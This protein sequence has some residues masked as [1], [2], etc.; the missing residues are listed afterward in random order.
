MSCS[1]LSSFVM[2]LFYYGQGVSWVGCLCSVYYVVFC[3]W[4]GLVLNQ[5]QVSL[6]VSDWESYLGYPFPTCVSWVF[7]FRV[8]VC[9]TRNYFGLV[10]SR[11]VSCFVS[12]FDCFNKEHEHVPCCTLVLRSLL[13]LL[14]VGG[15]G[16]QPLQSPPTVDVRRPFPHQL[17]W[18]GVTLGRTP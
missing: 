12:V 14:I 9:S 17:S 11:V 13:L 3:V 1:D 18:T 15:G 7:N 5:R 2:S 16:R 6:V 4:P 10:I 8:S